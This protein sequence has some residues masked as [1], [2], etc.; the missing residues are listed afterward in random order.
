MSRRFL[1]RRQPDGGW[2]LIELLV[3]LSIILIIMAVA[4]ASRGTPLQMGREATLRANL[5]MM[6]DAIDQYY[7]DT[8]RYPDSLQGLVEA[9]YMRAVPED[10]FTGSNAT[11]ETELPP[12]TFEGGRPRE[13]VYTVHSG[14]QAY[15]LDGTRV[16]GW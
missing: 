14:S 1:R 13:G 6:R 8:G 3:V 15:G 4:F 10:P 7:A 5:Q 2:T 11:W 9:E 16:S 12:L